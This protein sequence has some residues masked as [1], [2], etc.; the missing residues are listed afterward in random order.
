MGHGYYEDSEARQRL[1]VGIKKKG[2]D[3]NGG[4]IFEIT[5]RVAVPPKR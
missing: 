2:S 3:W 4:L 5:R 1:G